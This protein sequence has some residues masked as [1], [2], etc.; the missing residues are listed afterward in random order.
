MWGSCQGQ[1]LI[2]IWNYHLIP[3][4]FHEGSF[5]FEGSEVLLSDYRKGVNSSSKRLN[6]DSTT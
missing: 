5:W 3:E 4:N 1:T 6:G 2:S